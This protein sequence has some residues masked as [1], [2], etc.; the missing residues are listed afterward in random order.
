MHTP[1]CTLRPPTLHDADWMLSEFSRD[2]FPNEL[3][4]A[5]IS[6]QHDAIRWLQ[7]CID[8]S[9]NASLYSWVL[10]ERSTKTPVGQVT[11]IERE[12]RQWGLAYWIGHNFRRLGFASE[13]VEA[14]LCFAKT[15]LAPVQIVAGVHTWNTGSLRLLERQGFLVVEKQ[16]N[17]VLYGLPLSA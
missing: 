15:R 12:E 2:S 16:P 9:Y 10:I 11:L 17:F 8:G 4:L 5:Q 6:S 1:R 3:P 13:A 7:R 14:V